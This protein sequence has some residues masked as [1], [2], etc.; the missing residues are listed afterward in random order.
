MNRSASVDPATIAAVLREAA[1]VRRPEDFGFRPS[2]AAPVWGVVMELGTAEA[3]V[4][5]VVLLDGSVSVYLSDGD[6]VIGGGLHPDVRQSAQRMMAVAQRMCD[7]C[8]PV[9]AFPL[10]A[11]QQARLYLLCG[12]GVL[13]AAA[14]INDLDE[15]A[16]ELAELYYAGH[17]LISLIELLGAGNDL[18]DEI[19]LAES[20]RQRRL[21]FK[22]EA[23]D[24][25]VPIK[26]RSRGCRILPYVGNVARRSQH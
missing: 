13:G 10:P 15:G 14:P 17:A 22:N 5:L 12:H 16:L 24:V 26:P 6:G 20:A 8:Q 19:H 7:E 2:A 21:R 3:T 25:V 23:D 18:V 1:F 9:Y 4:T 11:D